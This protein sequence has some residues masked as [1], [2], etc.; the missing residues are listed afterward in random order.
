MQVK[1]GVIGYYAS[2]LKQITGKG[3]KETYP[4]V[5]MFGALCQFAFL[6]FHPSPVVWVHEI[7][8]MTVDKKV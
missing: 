6:S 2:E 3:K 1:V 5:E 8:L 7:R 4:Y